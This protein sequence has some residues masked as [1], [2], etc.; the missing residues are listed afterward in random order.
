MFSP[1]L[2]VNLGM[3]RLEWTVACKL[4]G[5][6]ETNRDL[7]K[8][9]QGQVQ[10]QLMVGGCLEVSPSAGALLLPINEDKCS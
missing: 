6:W 1:C 3:E 9:V 5:W 8:H 2:G 4:G 10:P 7:T